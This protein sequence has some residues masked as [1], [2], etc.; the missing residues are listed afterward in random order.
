MALPWEEYAT[1][2]TPPWQEYSAASRINNDAISQGARAFPGQ[3]SDALGGLSQ[4]ALNLLGG[5]VRG[6]GSI[7]STLA[8]PFES[9]QDNA[10]R[11]ARIDQN[12]Q[13]VGAQPNSFAYQGGK[14][15][16]EIAGTAAIPGMAGKS[17]AALLPALGVSAPVAN[18]VATAL[19][20]GGFRAP[21][22]SGIPALALRMGAGGLTGGAAAGLVDPTQA[23]DGALI[24]A[25]LPPSVQMAG[26]VG[27]MASD[28][29]KNGARSLMQSAAKPTLAQLKSGDAA[30][31]IDTMLKNGISPN[32]R[33]V[34]KVQG[35]VDATD[36][37]ISDAIANSTATI[38]KANALAP[39]LQTRAQFGTQVSPGSDLQ[40]IDGA[41]SGFLNHPTYPGM[42]LSVQDAQALKQ[43][44]YRV[45]AK[46]YGQ[47][48]SADTEAQKALARGLKDQIA[49]AVPSVSQDNAQ[50]S[51]LLSTLDVIQRRALM[52]GNKNPFG[53]GLLAPSKAGLLGFLADRSGALKALAARGMYSASDVPVTGLLQNPALI[54]YVRQGL[55][56]TEASP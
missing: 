56:A 6:A 39:V 9:S 30:T 17:A 49:A 12:M 34:E 54:P 33:G 3:G 40:A 50:L 22:A 26:A 36:Q 48:G 32:M 41:V 1:A 45:L 46:K 42:D 35:L 53:L 31:A 18:T 27:R 11:R 20:T 19:A 37:R 15:G 55:L 51:N 13:M 23:G 8:R 7:G 24:G 16:A 21:G 28:A 47:L 52:E 25:L 38:D 5:G 43:G 10:E 14:L 2:Q 44:T 4:F 29:M